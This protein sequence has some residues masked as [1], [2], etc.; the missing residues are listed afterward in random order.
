MNI[1]LVEKNTG[2]L[3]PLITEKVMLWIMGPEV[4]KSMEVMGEEY[5]LFFFFKKKAS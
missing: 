3:S 4:T 1:A 2:I 5:V